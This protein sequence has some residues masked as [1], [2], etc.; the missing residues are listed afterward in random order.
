[1]IARLAGPAA[2]DRT[3]GVHLQAGGSDLGGRRRKADELASDRLE[4]ARNRERKSH[5]APVVVRSGAEVRFGF[6]GRPAS[7]VADTR[8]QDR[9]NRR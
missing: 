4:K 2:P 5:D 1:M 3:R 7:H 6:K 8:V 9:G